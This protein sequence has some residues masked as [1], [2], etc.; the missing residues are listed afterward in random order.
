[1]IL[2]KREY[3]LGRKI[4]LVAGPILCILINL[5]PIPSASPE[6]VKVLSMAVWMI[7]WFVTEATDL[8]VTALLPMFLLPLMGIMPFGEVAANYGSSIIYLF[9]GGFVLALAMEKVNLHKRIALNIIRFTGTNANGVILGF[10][11]ATALLSMWISNTATALVVLP[12]AMTMIQFL[13]SD[14][15]LPEKGRRNFALATM[16]SIAYAANIGGTVTV[17][18]TPPNVVMIGYLESEYGQQ[19][20]FL[21]WSALG[22]PFALVMLTA[23]YFILTRFY[24]NRLG[25]LGMTREVLDTEIKKL[26]RRSDKENMVL[27]CFG[28]TAFLW[29]ARTYVNSLTGLGLSN[30]QIAIFGA[31]MVFTIPTNFGKGDFVLQW[32]DTSRLQWGILILFGGGLALAKALSQ[33]GIIDAIGGY[34]QEEGFTADTTVPFLISVMLFMTELMSNVALVAV[35][36]PMVDGIAQGLSMDFLHVAVPITL[37]SSCAFMLPMSTPPNAIVFVSGYIRVAEM[38]IVGFILNLVSI[39]LITLLAWTLIPI[40][41]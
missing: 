21:T 41:F 37:A 5:M 20:D 17:I 32:K 10:M 3:S 31:L 40:L 27:L 11:L 12:I 33:V 14:E 24:P 6:V 16:L 7:C 29:V 15:A 34:V 1:M 26:G 28:L 18:G 39:S 22:V 35:F 13:T 4:G 9:F 25:N 8:A 19:M 30:A 38:A 36:A 2:P 23:T